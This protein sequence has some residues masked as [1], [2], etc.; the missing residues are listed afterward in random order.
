MRGPD[1]NIRRVFC[2]FDYEYLNRLVKAEWIANIFDNA[3]LARALVSDS[4]AKPMGGILCLGDDQADSIKVA[5]SFGQ[6]ECLFMREGIE[7]LLITDVNNPAAFA[8]AQSTIPVVWDTTKQVGEWS[9]QSP[10]SMYNH[11]PG[12]ANILYMDGHVQFVRYPAPMT[13]ETWPLATISLDRRSIGKSPGW[14]W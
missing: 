14:A 9:S 6:V 13:Q 3:L 2:S 5:L 8:Q 4:A 7:R 11:V 10:I 1:D 12:G